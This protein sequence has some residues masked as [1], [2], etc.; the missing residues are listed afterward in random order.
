MSKKTEEL[1]EEMTRVRPEELS[2]EAHK[3]WKTICNI[4]DENDYLNKYKRK[5][6]EIWNFL[7]ENEKNIEP[8]L[9]AKLMLIL[10]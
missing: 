5:C 3:L 2:P 10:R 8:T 1:L 9:Y 4:L 6:V 7:E